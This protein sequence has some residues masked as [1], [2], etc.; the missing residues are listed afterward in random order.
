MLKWLRR[1][2]HVCGFNSHL[3]HHIFKKEREI[4]SG[5]PIQRNS[6]TTGAANICL[7]ESAVNQE[8]CPPRKGPSFASMHPVM[9]ILVLID[10]QV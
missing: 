6:E 3:M 2:E 7:V 10:V 9:F 8:V 4:R 5:Y 1:I